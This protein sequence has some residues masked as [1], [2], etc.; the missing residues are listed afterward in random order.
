MEVWFHHAEKLKDSLEF[1]EKI[2]H[3]LFS[4]PYP[5]LDT[6]Y[7]AV[8][9]GEEYACCVNILSG[10]DFGVVVSLST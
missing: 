1:F 8:A 10:S 6:V 4:N 7:D 9:E 2:L 5:Y 3:T